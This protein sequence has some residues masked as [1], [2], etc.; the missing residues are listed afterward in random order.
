[1]TLKEETTQLGKDARKIAWLRQQMEAELAEIRCV[2][3]FLPIDGAIFRTPI[4]PVHFN[5]ARGE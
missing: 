1:M 5:C 2:Q 4:G 3:C